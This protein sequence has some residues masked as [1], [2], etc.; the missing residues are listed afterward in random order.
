MKSSSALV[1]LVYLILITV[2]LGYFI[3]QTTGLPSIVV[4]QGTSM[5]PALSEGDIVYVAPKNPDKIAVGDVVAFKVRSTTL[6]HR[7]VNVTY[8]KGVRCFVTKGDANP[9]TDQD[10]G[11]TPL[12]PR[13]VIG[14][15]FS[16]NGWTWKI[17]RVGLVYALGHNFI[18]YWTSG[19][20]F[21]ILP[22]AVLG[23]AVMM[24]PNRRHEKRQYPFSRSAITKGMIAS[25][26]IF[27]IILMQLSSI[28]AFFF[29]PHSYSMVLGVE[30]HSYE[31]VDFNLGSLKLGKAKNVT[32]TLYASSAIR[33]LSKGVV[34][35]EGNITQ[36]LPIFNDTITIVPDNIANRIEM[37]AYSP[38][39][40]T[41]GVYTG[42][43]FVYNRPMWVIFPVYKLTHSLSSDNFLNILILDSLSNLMIAGGLT[44]F[45]LLFL[46]V[47]NRLADT[48]IWNYSN[49]E[50]IGWKIFSS[51]ERVSTNLRKLIS[52]LKTKLRLEKVRVMLKEVTNETTHLPSQM[53]P[54]L[55]VLCL[56]SFLGYIL[57]GLLLSSIVS[58]LYM[59]LV[60]KWVW[61]P[62]ITMVSVASSIIASTFYIIHWTI[63]NNQTQTVWSTFSL[64]A[65]LLYISLICL[66]AT[67]PVTYLSMYLALK[68]VAKSPG[69]SLNTLG[70]W[71]VVP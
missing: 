31:N 51:G 64:F 38:L 7:V 5:E 43:L 33:V 4:I 55:F 19:R 10:Y 18:L 35:I 3:F 30:T 36:L 13:D 29:R 6:V 61:R 39:N 34:Y 69:R 40:A 46:W 52:K 70:D 47:S 22:C 2:I 23:I 15:L 63:I 54:I 16:L 67:A 28:P 21:L 8:V 65:P 41:K 24:T 53:I 49:L 9:Y 45:Q 25:I 68:W 27:T 42:K 59:V 20:I 57:V 58:S 14:V 37:L 32:V 71:D 50:W 11:V 12:K 56:P 60:K 48:V 17:P 1:N 62:D 26:I 66:S 44:V